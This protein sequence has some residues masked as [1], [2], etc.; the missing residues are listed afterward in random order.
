M[1]KIEREILAKI[2]AKS[3]PLIGR[4]LP[5]QVSSWHIAHALYAPP[6][7]G[8]PSDSWDATPAQRKGVVRAM[9]S[10]VR[11][12]QQYGLMGGQGRKRLYLYDAADADSVAWARMQ[13][14]SRKFVPFSH[15][16]RSRA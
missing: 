10:F 15:V 8:R 2:V 14:E 11:K 6:P 5:V 1:G 13:V 7:T 4:P 9:H 12:Y 3:R 16:E